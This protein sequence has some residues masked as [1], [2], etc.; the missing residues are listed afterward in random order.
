MSDD[1]VSLAWNAVVHAGEVLERLKD[2][3]F[4]VEELRQ[5]HADIWDAHTDASPGRL[6]LAL[7]DARD[8]L[9]HARDRAEDAANMPVASQELSQ[10][11]RTRASLHS[12]FVRVHADALDLELRLESD[13]ALLVLYD[14]CLQFERHMNHLEAAVG[15]NSDTPD[16]KSTLQATK[17]HIIPAC[18]RLLVTIR[19]SRSISSQLPVQARLD[20]IESRWA[21]LRQQCH[22][23]D[24]NETAE[25]MNANLNVSPPSGKRRA[26]EQEDTRKRRWSLGTPSRLPRTPVNK[27]GSRI[28]GSIQRIRSMNRV[29]A[30]SPPMSAE[31]PRWTGVLASG[32]RTSGVSISNEATLTPSSPSIANEG[33]AKSALEHHRPPSSQGR[34]LRRRESMLPRL[35]RD[36]SSASSSLLS[37]PSAHSVPRVP[38]IPASYVTSPGLDRSR[39]RLR[40]H[41]STP[42]LSTHAN[43]DRSPT[44]GR[45]TPHST[46]RT[47]PGHATHTGRTT[48]GRATPGL[49]SSRSRYVPDMKDPLDIGVARIC[50]SRN[51]SLER[52][53]ETGRPDGDL[54]HRYTVLS[55][56]VACRLLRMVCTSKAQQDE[57]TPRL[58]CNGS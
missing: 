13:R 24:V 33:R 37:T 39:S 50:N 57:G 30:D 49:H 15:R 47:T 6:L 34:R 32:S 12:E 16:S 58:E 38:P 8:R 2:A 41:P 25:R 10:L 40:A 21:S 51:V 17:Q 55:K 46:G 53:D 36:S 19:S 1:G 31:G 27:I 29:Y 42:I 20:C 23:V 26:I 18:E 56:T 28:P 45:T 9:V 52:M 48:P 11:S 5:S 43:M 54:I 7:D 4:I 44:A 14:A 22:N 35:S 3:M